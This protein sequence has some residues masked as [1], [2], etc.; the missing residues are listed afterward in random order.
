MTTTPITINGVQFKITRLTTDYGVPASV[1]AAQFA[2]V[3]R[4]DV[5]QMQWG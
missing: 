2:E 5:R 4:N 1:I 3:H